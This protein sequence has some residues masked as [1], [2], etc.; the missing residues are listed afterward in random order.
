MF[1]VGAVDG[2]Y[3]FVK[4]ALQFKPDLNVLVKNST[5]GNETSSLSVACEKGLYAVAQLLI[6]HGAVN[7]KTD[8]SSCQ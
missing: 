3:D 8:R 4:W 2:R 1:L 7:N 5:T 6:S